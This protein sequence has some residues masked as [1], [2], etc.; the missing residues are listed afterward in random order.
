MFVPQDPTL[1]DVHRAGPSA[2]QR[3]GTTTKGARRGR[4]SALA[5][6]DGSGLGG[7][8]F[9]WG[10]EFAVGEDRVAAHHR[11]GVG[12]GEEM[13]GTVVVGH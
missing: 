3:E 1:L 11:I 6:L 9:G 8:L 7:G 13:L 10:G 5:K 2:R 12:D 4:R